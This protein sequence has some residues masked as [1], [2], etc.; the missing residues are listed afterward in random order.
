M[1]GANANTQIANLN[2]VNLASIL[3]AIKALRK[4]EADDERAWDRL[5]VI[6]TSGW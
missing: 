2:A 3:A 1:P 5:P 4:R 6:F